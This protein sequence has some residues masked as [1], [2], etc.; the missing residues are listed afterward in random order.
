MRNGDSDYLQIPSS[1]AQMVSGGDGLCDRFSVKAVAIGLAK[2]KPGPAN[3][4]FTVGGT[5]RAYLTLN[6]AAGG[7]V[8]ALVA[9]P[10]QAGA[11]KGK[12]GGKDQRGNMSASSRPWSR[13]RRAPARKAS[14]KAR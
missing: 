10:A 8:T 9:S 7:P 6:R 3:G 14:T 13:R 12:A 4:E 1:I 11:L 2:G 5:H